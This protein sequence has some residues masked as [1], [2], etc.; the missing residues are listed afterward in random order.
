M[1]EPGLGWM[2]WEGLCELCRVSLMIVMF[3]P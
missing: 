2:D 1:M 3:K